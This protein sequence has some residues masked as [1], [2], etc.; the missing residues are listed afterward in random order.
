MPRSPADED[1]FHDSTM[2]FGQHLEE[3]RA[4]LFKS[5]LGLIVGCVVGLIVG[6]PVVRFIQTP[7]ESALVKYYEKRAG[8]KSFDTVEL[9]KLDEAGYSK[10]EDLERLRKIVKKGSVSFDVVYVDPGE[11][12]GNVNAGPGVAGSGSPP[13]A[14]PPT[15]GKIEGLK[16]LVLFRLVAD[17]PRTHMRSLSFTE[18]FMIYMKA[19]LLVGVVLASPWVFYQIWS[20]VAAGLYPHERRYVHVFLP[21]SIMLFLAGASTAFFLVFEK[22][23][24]FLLSFNAMLGIDPDLRINEWIGFVLLLPLGFGVSFQLPLVMLFLERVGIFTVAAY[25]SSWRIAIL[26]IFVLAMLLSPSGDPYSLLLMAGPLTVLYFGG[27]LMCKLLPR[28]SRAIV[29]P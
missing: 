13:E 27:A 29:S 19:S 20:F 14:G 23:L 3:L 4:C 15:A 10:P 28:R 16:P 26:A 11:V 6:A 21:V 1:L 18:T 12:A 22:V 9:E 24:S 8:E 5:I 25:L 7:A 17:D 2:T